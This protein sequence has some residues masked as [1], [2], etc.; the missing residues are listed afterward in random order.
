MGAQNCHEEN[1]YGA[2]TGNV[3][4]KMIKNLGAKHLIL[5]HSENRNNG[6]TNVIINK[7]INNA[8]KQKLNVI[9]CI[10]ETLS[11]KRRKETNKILRK[12]IIKGLK[13]I[14]KNSRLIIAYEPVWSIGTGIIPKNYELEKNIKFINSTIKINTKLKKVKILYGGSVNPKNIN[15][16]NMINNI[17]GY[18]IGGASQN[19][20]KLIDIV[21]KTYN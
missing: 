20:K 17:D 6:E 7:K 14:K 4:A 9:F 19:A 11:Q 8:L 2:F 1:E 10:G 16:L 13:G 15:T 12:Q 5:G 18:L 21:K 3:N